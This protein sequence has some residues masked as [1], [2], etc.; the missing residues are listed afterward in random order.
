MSFPL[1]L[2]LRHLR[3]TPG[4]SPTSPS[5]MDAPPLP[6]TVLALCHRIIE[7]LC[8]KRPRTPENH[9]ERL[10]WKGPYRSQ[11]HKMVGLEGT[12]FYGR[13][14]GCLYCKE[15]RS[16]LQPHPC[17]GLAVPSAQAAQSP[18]TASGTSRDGGPTALGSSA[19]A[20]PPS[21]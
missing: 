16:P 17:R 9:I 3:D 14:I 6:H 21:G 4:P 5:G 10:D 18:S 19:G 8:W 2:P 7:W 11:N 20:S 1:A 13:T 12:T 15:L